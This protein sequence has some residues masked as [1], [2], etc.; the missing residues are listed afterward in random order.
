MGEVHLANDTRLD[1]RVAVKVLHTSAAAR[2]VSRERF[3]T[4]A[5]HLQSESSAHLRAL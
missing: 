3:H 4:E 1:R 5:S 2:G